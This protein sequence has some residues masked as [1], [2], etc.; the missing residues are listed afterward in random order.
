MGLG[1]LGFE[2][3]VEGL[4]RQVSISSSRVW[5]VGFGVQCSGVGVQFAG[6]RVWEIVTWK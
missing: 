1:D 6:V 3:G 2:V 5:G 4:D